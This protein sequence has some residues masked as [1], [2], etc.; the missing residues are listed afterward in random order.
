MSTGEVTFLIKGTYKS[1]SY[2]IQSK[3]KASS[4][5]LFW[6]ETNKRN[7]SL[8]YAKNQKSPFM[9]EQ[10]EYAV[11]DQIVFEDGELRVPETNPVLIEFLRKHPRFNQEFYEWDPAKDNKEKFDLEEAILDAK[12]IVRNLS[13]EKKKSLIRLYTEKAT[14]TIDKMDVSEINYTAIK[15]AEQFPYDVVESIEDPEMEIDDIAIR[16]VSDGYVSIRNSGRDIHYNLEGNKKRALVVPF[17]EDPTSALSAW[18]KTDEGLELYNKIL[19]D[20]ERD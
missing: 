8:R 9:D 1:P 7:R 15:I 14:S 10:D 11:V 17:G 4:P 6:D 16:A 18:L 13:V 5:L 2:I 3:H 12:I 19:S 20:I